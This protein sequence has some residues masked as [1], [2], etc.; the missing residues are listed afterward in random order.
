[1]HSDEELFRDKLEEFCVP[2]GK[3]EPLPADIIAL[4]LRKNGPTVC[5]IGI[6]VA[7]PQIIHARGGPH[8]KDGRVELGDLAGPYLKLWSGTWRLRTWCD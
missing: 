2:M 7:H 3:V 1:M 6:T 8:S 5:H 4:Q